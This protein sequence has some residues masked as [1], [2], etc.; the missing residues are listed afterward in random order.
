MKKLM[1][2]IL[3]IA[4]A[5]SVMS[6][7][8]FADEVVVEEATSSVYTIN[9]SRKRIEGVAP[10]TTVQAFEANWET[11]DVQVVNV[12]GSLMA[13]DAY[14]TDNVYAK[15]NGEFYNIDVNWPYD[16]VQH[17]GRN[18]RTDGDV[19]FEKESANFNSTVG[20]QDARTNS[21]FA[22]AT[23][24]YKLGDASGAAPTI[25][26]GSKTLIT[27]QTNEVGDPIYIIA[28]NAPRY[29]FLRSHY[30]SASYES[31]TQSALT[32]IT[33]GKVSVTTATF[34]AD[35]MGNFSIHHNAA[36][37][38][39]S[40]KGD[41]SFDTFTYSANGTY[42]PNAVHFTEDGTIKV[43]GTYVNGAAAA[44][45]TPAHTTSATW[46]AGKEYTVSIVQKVNDGGSR[47]GFVYGIYVNGEKIF[48][49]GSHAADSSGHFGYDS[50]RAATKMNTRSSDYKYLGGI[51][52]VLV[53]AAPKNASDDFSVELSDLKVYTVDSAAAYEATKAMDADIELVSTDANITID[54]KAATVVS[55]LG[56]VSADRFNM[57]GYKVAVNGNV[58]T[59][60]S[61]DGL[62]AKKYA[63]TH[64]TG[65]QAGFYNADTDETIANLTGVTNV[66]FT[67]IIDKAVS[68]D[69]AGI[70]PVVILAVYKNDELAGAI[71]A[72]GA[73]YAGE[74][75]KY[76]AEYNI[77]SVETVAGDEISVRAFVWNSTTLAPLTE[78]F[79]IQ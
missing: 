43:G 41:A 23:S 67:A 45:R 9:E 34:K 18:Y 68:S 30:S 4:L 57:P 39:T 29:G 51:S 60:V 76:T 75:T 8:V 55:T 62:T 6:I 47:Y 13:D 59:V 38:A 1:A 52:A 49:T 40:F 72:T 22:Y 53:G 32:T 24:A 54:N 12:D 21:G 42:I 28:N 11:G 17:Y 61:E 15:I 5:L 70:T 69:F 65:M 7:G 26:S 2:A 3:C 71:K 77:S 20:G 64:G 50:S 63:V 33:K 14:A 35:M 16:S 73:A 78:S 58:L 46:E 25:P 37:Y 79:D 56:A 66:G 36:G 48:P 31:S 74:M 44:A 10:F 19:I 27:K